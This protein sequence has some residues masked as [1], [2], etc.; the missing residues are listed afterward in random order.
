M[1]KFR[2]GES[3]NPGGIPKIIPEGKIGKGRTVALAVL[4]EMLARQPNRKLLLRT[5][6]AEFREHPM[7]FFKMV[8]MPLLPK[9]GKV[10][11]AADGIVQWKGITETFGEAPKPQTKE[12]TP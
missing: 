10:S 1:A 7:A 4:D 11:L 5:L 9:E 8:I 3:G 12:R 6:E 2:K